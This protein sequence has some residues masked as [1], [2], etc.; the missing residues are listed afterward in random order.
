MSYSQVSPG[1]STRRG[2]VAIYLVLCV[3][4]AEIHTGK[5]ISSEGACTRFSRYL[6]NHSLIVSDCKV[7]NVGH[8]A[9]VISCVLSLETQQAT[10][11]HVCRYLC[12]CVGCC[13]LGVY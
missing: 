10:Q 11:C 8:V 3:I 13:V 4:A 9:V 6:T 7:D 5:A 2:S 12:I 1:P